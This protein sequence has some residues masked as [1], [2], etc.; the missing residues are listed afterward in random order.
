MDTTT[1]R[2]IVGALIRAGRK[3]LARAFLAPRCCREAIA[4]VERW[5][6]EQLKMA[7]AA[8]KP[9]DVERYYKNCMESKTGKA[10]GE[11]AE[12]YC[13]AVAWSIYCKHKKPDSPHCKQK[14]YFTGKGA[15]KASVTAEVDAGQV[16]KALKPPAGWA[17]KKFGPKWFSL[18]RGKEIGARKTT[19]DYY[20][21][22]IDLRIGEYRFAGRNGVY[23]KIPIPDNLSAAGVAHVANGIMNMMK[24][25]PKSPPKAYPGIP[26]GIL[27]DAE[28]LS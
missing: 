1:K 21:I 19:A 25:V 22:D 23:K 15:P 17:L 5:T 26:H 24:K 4:A 2:Q 27:R 18:Q 13:S 9:K 10:K 11:R 14:E 7:L 12:A 20:R 16:D 3:D 6:P 8:E 28:K